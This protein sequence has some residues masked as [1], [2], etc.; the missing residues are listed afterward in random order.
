[1][2][3]KHTSPIKHWMAWLYR[4]WLRR[5]IRG[6][7]SWTL[8]TDPEPGCTAIIG[9][10][11][12]LPDV[13]AAN[14]LCLYKSR[15]PALKRI[16][17]AVDTVHSESFAEIEAN[18]RAICPTLEVDFIYYTEHQFQ[19]AGQ[20]QLPYVYAWLSWCLAL[21]TVTTEHALIHDYD[22][23][24]LGTILGYRYKKFVTSKSKIQ[25]VSWYNG[26]GV[27]ATDCLATTFEAFLETAWWRTMH[28]LALFN[29]MELREGRSIDYDTFL[30]VQDRQLAPDQRTMV[31]MN[32]D[33][34][35]HPSQMIHQYT[36]FRRHPERSL[37]CFSMP[38]IPFFMYLGGKKD[39]IRFALDALRRTPHAN[40][41]FL[42][43]GTRFNFHRLDI[44]Q[45]DWA[46]K[47]MVQ[48]FI[49]L[50]LP[51]E[52]VV[53]QYGEALYA[54]VGAP[55]D[56]VWRGDFSEEQRDWIK[57]AKQVADA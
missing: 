27:L 1:M 31:P 44:S 53:Y 52:N 2:R 22:A 45:V 8:L 23:L 32:L 41:D 21:A 35:V 18:A 28:P 5:R 11:S 14:L 47:Q 36:M 20:L 10:C 4:A 15:W 37:P 55:P 25:G 56:K 49:A 34:M 29:K 48:A 26:N 39:A 54:I 30:H 16:V 12:R 3:G 50:E 43:D 38:M 6:L 13:M 42:G 40:V 51:A 17:I 7:V 19:I 9:M 33:E 24:I 46:L 57:K